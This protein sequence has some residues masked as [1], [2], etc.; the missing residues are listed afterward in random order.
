MD[1]IWDAGG[2]NRMKEE[3]I[4]TKL[5]A[6]R[7]E[8][9]PYV[10]GD[11]HL[12]SYQNRHLLIERCGHILLLDDSLLENIQQKN[13]PEDLLVKLIQRNFVDSN[14]QDYQAIA[15][16]RTISPDFFM[17][18]ITKKCNMQCMYCFRDGIEDTVKSI[19][20]N[21]LAD[22]C[23]FIVSQIKQEASD[24]EIMIQPWG[25][26]PLLELEKIFW[27]QD[28][29]R[30][31][32]IRACIS[33]ETNGVLINEKL[34]EI[35]RDREI[36]VGVSLDGI[37]KV[38]NMQRVDR[39]N[40]G[41]FHDVVNGFRALRDKMGNMVGII[42]T[43]TKHTIPHVEDC[44]DFFAKELG[45][46]YIKTN[47]V[48][49]SDFVKNDELC[50][51]KEEMKAC[52]HRIFQKIM[53][54]N[55]EGYDFFESNI[56]I[57]LLNLLGRRNSSICCSSGCNGGNRMIA[58]DMDGFIYPCELTDYPDERIGHIQDGRSLFE[59]I[60]TA[61]GEKDYFTIKKEK[62]C[63]DCPWRYY[64]RGGCTVQAKCMGKPAGTID[65]IECICNEVWYG[66]LVEMILKKPDVINHFM[67]GKVLKGF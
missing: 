19:R 46:N 40:R 2:Y 55:E 1:Q 27:M 3:F 15:Q 28:R 4:H 48:H 16:D 47:F 54:L 37:E 33:I 8:S 63:D 38:H 5:K 6:F 57:R 36:I 41:T 24:R 26:E 20:K 32:G 39:S 42:M 21:E 56:Q 31:A 52:A 58:F 25:G 51:S 18:D 53:S 29:F 65:D 14:L 23:D 49:K 64:C 10:F 45:I 22:I 11:A 7:M 12:F 60:S 66:E 35:L 50:L 61:I 67:N 30:E 13:V 34:A 62:K 44:L 59:M 17:I 43:V 9:S